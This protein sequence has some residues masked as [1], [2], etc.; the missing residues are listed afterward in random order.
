MEKLVGLVEQPFKRSAPKFHVGDTVRVW[1][2]I[3][4][5]PVEKVAESVVRLQP[6]EGIVIRCR[7][8]GLSR[9]FTV[10]RLSFGIGVE[11]IF[12]LYSPRI[13]KIE[14]LKSGRVRRARLY[15][16]RRAIGRAARVEGESVR[17]SAE[18]STEDASVVQRSEKGNQDS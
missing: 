10:R 5:T 17:E 3:V 15:Y 16:L 7:G 9:T 13:E 4:E 12:P 11:R 18:G 14:V 8:E 1:F 6:F 2:K